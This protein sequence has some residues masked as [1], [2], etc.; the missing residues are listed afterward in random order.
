MLQYSTTY[1]SA[2]YRNFKLIE[3]TPDARYAII[4]YFEAHVAKIQHLDIDEYFEL[5]VA[6]NEAL[7]EVGAHQL[8]LKI[9]S[10]VINVSIQEN[11]KDFG[12]LDIFA[13]TLFYKAQ[14][15]LKLYEIKAAIHIFKELIKMYPHE[16]VYQRSLR[17]SYMLQQP[18]YLLHAKAVFIILNLCIAAIIGLNLFIITPFYPELEQHVDIVR[19]ICIAVAVLV[20]SAAKVIQYICAKQKV[21]FFCK[22][23]GI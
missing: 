10:Q 4:R 14:S 20:L 2:I 3:A 22:K 17:D 16:I 15:H 23:G 8:H 21:T 7:Y 1:Y 11:I 9:S 18:N 12:G 13:H 6:Y 5:L 19:N